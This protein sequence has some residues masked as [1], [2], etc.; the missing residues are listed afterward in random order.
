M[1]RGRMLGFA[2]LLAMSKVDEGMFGRIFKGRGMSVQKGSGVPPL[3]KKPRW[4]KHNEIVPTARKLMP[5]T[6]DEETNLKFF[7]GRWKRHYVIVLKTKYNFPR[8]RDLTVEEFE[9]V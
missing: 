4:N 5:L 9:A 1:S 8:T 6:K 7:S 3:P 2:A